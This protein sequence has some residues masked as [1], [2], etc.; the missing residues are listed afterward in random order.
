MKVSLIGAETYCLLISLMGLM[1]VDIN[2][3]QL[4][5]F[6]GRLDKPGY[7]REAMHAYGAVEFLDRSHPSRPGFRSR[8]SGARLCARPVRFPGHVVPS[9]CSLRLPG[10]APVCPAQPRRVSHPTENGSVP[11]DVLAELGH[12]Q[13]VYRDAYFSV[14]H[15]AR[16]SDQALR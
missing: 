1:I 3:P 10:R 13:R 4:S 5:Y 16:N 14:Y 12:P 9:Q 15:L 11:S 6:A 2:G 7:L 8:K